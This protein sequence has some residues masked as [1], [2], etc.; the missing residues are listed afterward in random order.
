MHRLCV[1]E[2]CSEGRRQRLGIAW[3]KVKE[4]AL[5]PDISSIGF[6]LRNRSWVAISCLLEVFW[7]I[8]DHSAMKNY[9][10]VVW[11]RFLRCMNLADCVQFILWSRFLQSAEQP[12]RTEWLSQRRGGGLFM[13]GPDWCGS[14]AMDKI[15]RDWGLSWNSE[16]SSKQSSLSG[17]R[18]CWFVGGWGI[19]VLGL[20]KFKCRSLD[21]LTGMS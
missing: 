1:E 17:N 10:E 7:V 18:M 16:K 4:E 6:G 3:D 15:I 11:G 21:L 12:A 5:F 2:W 9:W 14:G 19:E 13:C 8:T 20:D